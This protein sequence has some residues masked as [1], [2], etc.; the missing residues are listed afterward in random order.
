[1]GNIPVSMCI[2]MYTTQWLNIPD[3][4]K[5]ASQHDIRPI[6]SKNYTGT[7]QEWNRV[8]S[9]ILLLDYYDSQ[10]IGYNPLQS[11]NNQAFE[12]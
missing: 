9:L 5:Y 1:M 3:C 12:H 10:Y 6:L 8:A 11:S 2:H 7:T 4:S